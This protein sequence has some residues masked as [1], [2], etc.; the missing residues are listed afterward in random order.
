MRMTRRDWD[1]ES[2]SADGDPM[3][4]NESSSTDGEWDTPED[5]YVLRVGS[6][7][8]EIGRSA[9]PFEHLAYMR[10]MC[11][12]PV[13][14]ARIWYEA[15]FMLDGVVEHLSNVQAPFDCDYSYFYTHPSVV[16][17]YVDEALTATGNFD[18]C[19]DWRSWPNL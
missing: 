8:V 15:G 12:Q 16:V 10:D 17:G 13:S 2:S 18:L 5:L 9:D 4:D 11:P 3:L 7:L 14:I 19:A 6:S 1:N